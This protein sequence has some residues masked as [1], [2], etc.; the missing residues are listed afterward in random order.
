MRLTKNKRG[1]ELTMSTIIIAV[2]VIIVLLVLV[3]IFSKSARNFFLGTSGC[4][5]KGGT[6]Q[7]EC[8]QGETNHFAGNPE[9][10]GKTK[11]YICCIREATLLGTEDDT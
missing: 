8:G 11:G 3:L 5:S 4:A 10:D 1:A 7:A 6:C 9:C 2:L